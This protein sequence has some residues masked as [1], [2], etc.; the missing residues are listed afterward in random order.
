MTRQAFPAESSAE[1]GQ[2]EDEHGSPFPKTFDQVHEARDLGSGSEGGPLL[3][4]TVNRDDE[5]HVSEAEALESETV[6]TSWREW[7]NCLK[8]RGLLQRVLKTSG[9]D[10]EVIQGLRQF[11]CP[12]C[13]SRKVPACPWSTRPPNDYKLKCGLF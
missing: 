4:D 6:R 7:R 11:Y 5:Q 13:A 12:S 10:P 9:G 3:N 2:G 1:D 8:P